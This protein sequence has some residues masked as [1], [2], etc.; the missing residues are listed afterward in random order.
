MSDK[1]RGRQ[2][3]SQSPLVLHNAERDRN[4]NSEPT[5]EAESLWGKI[6]NRRMGDRAIVR[7]RDPEL[8]E[9]LKKFKEKS[10]KKKDA[11]DLGRKKAKKDLFSNL[12]DTFV[13]GYRPKTKETRVPYE[14]LLGFVSNA[15]GDLQQEVIKSAADEILALLK[16]EGMKAPEKRKEIEALVNHSITDAQFADIMDISKKI[17]DYTEET[18][19]TDAIDDESGVALVFDDDED[20]DEFE[21]RDESDD[22]EGQDTDLG[23]FI[24]TEA[25]QQE[26]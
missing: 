17:T 13:G 21:L 10:K 16:T 22:E 24:Q 9:K 1:T 23:G 14:Q 20:E 25:D 4:R 18:A 2:M 15:L 11:S 19:E 12:E 26:M 6:G 3:E 7:E 5:G 8:E